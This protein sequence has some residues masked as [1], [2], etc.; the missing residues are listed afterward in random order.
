MASWNLIG[1]PL[2]IRYQ[3]LTVKLQKAET[4]NS[5]HFGLGGLNVLL[6][7]LLKN[8]YRVN[9]TD[10]PPRADRE[11][12][13]AAPMRSFKQRFPCQFLVDVEAKKTKQTKVI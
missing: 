10:W 2:S 4:K 6:K 9:E 11:K 8:L 13:R 3:I 1:C 7:A 5:G 12:E